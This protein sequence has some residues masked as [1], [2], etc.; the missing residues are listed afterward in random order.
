[1]PKLLHQGFFCVFLIFYL[2]STAQVKDNNI[3]FFFKKDT[4][5][6]RERKLIDKAFKVLNSEEDQKIVKIAHHL[7]KT[8]KTEYAKANSNLLLAYYYKNRTLI[9]SSIYY[10]EESLKFNKVG[11][12]SLSTRGKILAYNILAI[13]YKNKGLLDE[14]KKWHQK[15]IAL[16]EDFKEKNLYFTQLHGLALT[17]S[18]LGNY[19]QSLELFEECLTYNDEPEIIYGSYINIGT[20]Y[21]NLKDFETSNNYLKKAEILAIK[22][23]QYQALAVIAL[24]LGANY[25]EMGENK[26]AIV[27]YQKAAK[28][29]DKQ[30]FQKISLLA[31]ANIG[32]VLMV[33]GNYKDAELILSECLY[34]AI[35]LGLFSTQ[36]EIYKDLSEIEKIRNN[37]KSALYFTTQYYKVKDSINQLQKD[38]E[39]SEL[40]VKYQTIKKEKEIKLLLA[41]N[42]NRNLELELER[43]QAIRQK[44]FKNVILYSFLILLIPV[45]GLLI[46]YY[47]KIQTQSELNQKQKEISRQKIS[48]LLKDQE[49]KVIKASIEGQDK[50]RK[51]IAQELHDSIGG[52]L[53]AIKLQL[54]NASEKN[55]GILK[56]INPQIDDTYELV[57]NLSHNL[58]PKKFS[59]NNFCDVL[60]EYF[61]NIGDAS[62]LITSFSAYTRK[63]IDLLEENLQDESFKIIQE[64]ITNTIKHSKASFIELQITLVE[65]IVNIIFEDNGQGFDVNKNKDG[66]GFRNIKS[67]LENI[68]GTLFI[69]S[70]INRGTI[71]D[72]SIPV[73]TKMNEEKK[74]IS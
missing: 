3:P 16:T 4:L 12:D 65:K 40:E 7:L 47:Q 57:R 20:I 69:D 55:E 73:I 72:I 60:E 56:R 9:D 53:A 62:N 61:N 37:Y 35:E 64:L 21:A 46:T 29:A 31:K 43:E 34:K 39:I 49:L 6:D 68:S 54:N 26:K 24:N 13:N 36:M 8:V 2:T 74:M 48:S 50:E 66:I 32:D 22:D 10:V 19:Q 33:I 38:K 30:Q 23:N 52:N 5:L 41:E 14:S 59:K 17:Y 67:R 28:V 42:S 11:N 63:E 15:G 71:I 18:E 58:I 27:N 25:Q 70:R 45:I 1:M 44:G 51:R